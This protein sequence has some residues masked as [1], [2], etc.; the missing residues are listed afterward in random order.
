MKKKHGGKR[1][2]AGAKL[3]YNEATKVVSVRIPESKVGEF[4]L[5]INQILKTYK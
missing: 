2:G 5:K 4:K 1:K 3:K